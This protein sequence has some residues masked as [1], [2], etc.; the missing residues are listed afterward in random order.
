MQGVLQ[1]LTASDTAIKNKEGFDFVQ[2]LQLLYQQNTTSN[3]GHPILDTLGSPI[4]SCFSYRAIPVPEC[5]GF[6]YIST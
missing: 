1:I 4:Q 5:T 2:T 6:M 3:T